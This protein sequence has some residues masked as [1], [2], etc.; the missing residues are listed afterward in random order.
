ME[1]GKNHGYRG[2]SCY[3]CIVNPLKIHK[4]SKFIEISK[5]LLNDLTL[6]VLKNA[7]HV[8]YSFVKFNLKND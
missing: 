4:I 8:N 7:D 2:I 6:F 3:N 5:E 1:F